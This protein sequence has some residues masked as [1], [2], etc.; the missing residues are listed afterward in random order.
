MELASNHQAVL[1]RKW[2]P[3]KFDDLV[4]QEP[5]VKTLQNAIQNNQ[6]SHAYLFTG[7]R[8]TGKTTAGRIFAATINCKDKENECFEHFF[9]GSALSLIELD[10][11]SNRGIDEIRNLKENIAYMVGE[12]QFK[13][14]LIDEVHMLT[15]AAFNALLKTLEEPPAHVIFILA[16]TE[17]HKVPT[18]VHSRCQRYDFRKINPVDTVQRLAIIADAESID[19]SEDSLKFI[20]RLSEGSLRDAINILEQVAILIDEEIT[21]ENMM[22]ALGVNINDKCTPFLV[23]LINYELQECLAIISSLYEGGINFKIF[24]DQLIDSL[25]SSLYAWDNSQNIS[26]LYLNENDLLMIKKA[27]NN[28]VERIIVLLKKISLI[29]FQ[30]DSFY[31]L[32]LEIV[33]ADICSHGSDKYPANSSN[34]IN[35]DKQAPAQAKAVIPED[36]QAP[37]QPSD[38]VDNAMSHWNEI[39]SEARNNNNKAGA[40]MNSGCFVKSIVNNKMTIGFK[41]ATHVELVKNSDDGKVFLA[42]QTAVNKVLESN[43]ELEIEVADQNINEKDSL[44]SDNLKGS[45]KHLVDEALKRGAKI[46]D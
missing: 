6:A 20:A 36:K 44:E 12:N 46:I 16:T 10:A 32:P 4:G 2:R 24:R 21:I 25:R 43:L 13:V 17:P 40:L 38:V 5:I 15:D 42:I 33:I 45:G 11:A 8:G 30:S 37:A 9:D 1:Y 39:K 31:P 35:V 28:D 19:I 14:Y 18:T 7:P 34:N 26:S 29:N 3:R 41:F 22:P 23:N 27:S